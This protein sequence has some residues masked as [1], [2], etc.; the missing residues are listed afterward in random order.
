MPRIHPHLTQRA[1]Q[2]LFRASLS[3]NQLRKT[4]ITAISALEGDANRAEIPIGSGRSRFN[5][6]P[7]PGLRASVFAE[8]I[9]GRGATPNRKHVNAL[10]V[11]SATR[12]HG[13]NVTGTGDR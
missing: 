5:F 12:Q 11:A 7:S 8:A 13:T 6:D 2:D 9:R 3:K 1:S 10:R 4:N